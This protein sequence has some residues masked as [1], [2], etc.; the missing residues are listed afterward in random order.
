MTEWSD[1]LQY[2]AGNQRALTVPNLHAGR[3]NFE[4][5]VIDAFDQIHYTGEY[6]CFAGVRLEVWR[7]GGLFEDTSERSDVAS[8]Y[9]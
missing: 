6:H 7:H 8:K 9:D 2:H 4:I 1:I 3:I 5:G